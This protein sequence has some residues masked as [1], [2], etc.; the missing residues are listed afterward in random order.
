MSG[1]LTHSPAEAIREVLVSLGVGTDPTLG[2][3]WPVYVGDVPDTPDQALVVNQTSSILEGRTQTDG[4]TQQ[5]YGIITTIRAND[6]R[7]GYT[8]GNAVASAFDSSIDNTTVTVVSTS[9]LIEAVSIRAGGLL[10]IGVEPEARGRNLFTV[11]AIVSLYQI[12]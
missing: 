3:A 5:H 7:T 8:K 6:Y 9:Y 4:E 11:N 12:A 2:N 1:S 10:Y